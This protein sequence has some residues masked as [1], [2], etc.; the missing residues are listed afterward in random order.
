M[1]KS[2]RGIHRARGATRQIACAQIATHT[3]PFSP[4]R[5]SLLL[6]YI[7]VA[8]DTHI[9]RS[10]THGQ[11]QHAPKAVHLFSQ[12]LLVLSLRVVAEY[13]R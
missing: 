4:C 6:T 12:L 7:R 2:R 9:Q 5:L 8:T 1:Q 10:I 11:P 3:V 13:G